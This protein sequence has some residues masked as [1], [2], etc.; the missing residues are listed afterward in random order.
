MG[1]VTAVKSCSASS[2]AYNSDGC[3]AFAVTIGGL[4]GKASCGTFVSLDA[5]GGLPVADGHVGACQRLECVHNADLMCTA[6]SVDIAGD[7]ACLA[8]QAR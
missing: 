7:A 2:C 1:T 5:R 4:A 3:T 6:E 8:Y